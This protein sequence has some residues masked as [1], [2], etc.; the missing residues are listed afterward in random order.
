MPAAIEGVIFDLGNTLFY[1]EG[2]WPRVIAQS[3]AALVDALEEAG[4]DLDRAGFLENFREELDAYYQERETEFIE[5]T[6]FFVLRN[7]LASWG[8][9]QVPETIL[10]PALARMYAVSQACWKVEE[11]THETLL[12]LRSAGYRLGV[13]SN[14]ADDAD[15]QAL[16]DKA[17][18]R[19]FFAPILTS[20]AA[21]IR[22]PNPAIFERVLE[23]WDLPPDR[24]AMV[25]DSLG[26]DILGAQNAG[27]HSIWIT[28]RAD[29]PANRAHRD[30]IHPEI[31]VAELREV[32]AVLPRLKR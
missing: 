22:K 28:R 12:A 21:G 30:T 10:R 14:A 16:I 29:T 5:Y 19:H 26:A 27:I 3:D 1:F 11:D 32:P 13:I 4:L 25:G 7:L 20:A 9:P 6:T 23:Q 24:V 15:V 18:I 31:T 2:S 17:G 8:Y